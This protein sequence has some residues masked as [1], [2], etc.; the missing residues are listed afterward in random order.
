MKS[1]ALTAILGFALTA[2]GAIA[3]VI[4]DNTVGTIVSPA[5]LI[6]GGT[7]T[8]NNLF[9]SFSQF[10]IP[11]GGSATFDNP[12]NIQ[13]IFS[14]VTGTTKS[15]IDGL[16]QANGNTNL[17][18][19]NPNGIVFGPNAKLQIGGSFIGTTANSIKFADGVQ[20]SAGDTTPNPLLTVSLPIG[21][22]M[23]ANSGAIEVQGPGHTLT[24]LDS[25]G[26]APLIQLTRPGLQ[27]RPGQLLALVGSDVKLNNGV[28]GAVQGRVEI[29]SLA[30]GIVTLSI[31]TPSTPFS[32][33]NDSVFN[34]VILTGRS[35]LDVSGVNAGGIQIQGRQIS[36][37]DGSVIFSQNFGNQSGGDIKINASQSLIV[38]G[39]SS[40]RRI[41]TAIESET[42]GLGIGS[43]IVINSPTIQVK[44]G[45]RIAAI[46][47]NRSPIASN[48][49]SGDIQITTDSLLLQGV[50]IFNSSR[51]SSLG[52]ATAGTGTSGSVSVIAKD[53]Q[54]LDGATLSTATFG[55]G[56]SGS[57]DLKADTVM[58]DHISPLGSPSA[59]G[60]VSFSNG[61]S[62]TVK[63]DT[64]S[65]KI[66]NGGSLAATAYAKGNAG[67][68]IVNAS[69][70]VQLQGFED[71]VDIRNRSNIISAS[72]IPS[73]TFIRLLNLTNVPSGTAGSI[74][75]NTPNLNLTNKALISV[76]NQGTGGGGNL[77]IAAGKIQLSQD[78]KLTAE[79]YSGLGGDIILNSQF[80]S[81]R[82]ASNITA[83]AG[84]QGNGGNIKINSPIIVGLEN[85][86]IIANAFQGKGGAI[87]ITTDGLLGLKYRDRLTTENDITASS[88]FGINGTVQIDSFGLDPS[89]GLSALPGDV[90]DSSRA[91]AKGCAANQGNRFVSTG[92]GGIPQNPIKTVKHDRPWNDLRAMTTST[93]VSQIQNPK[94]KI[95]EATH[96]QTNSDG[97]IA[98]ADGE[99]MASDLPKVIGLNSGATCAVQ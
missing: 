78:S 95:V 56:M 39:E 85:S 67:N 37:Q 19:M 73:L 58:L 17:F 30:N 34:A 88:E 77:S 14:R 50:S 40:D 45:A 94:F 10:S 6:T 98:L 44:Q 7:R 15:S 75:I 65:L 21:L 33:S 8:G 12:A 26:F 5:N 13:T 81:L 55:S 99:S 57:I 76:R 4:P 96:I 16:I 91:I 70:S 24:P 66:F 48:A 23:G 69:E 2:Q 93:I 28:L 90:I 89:S 25:L 84:S 27:V 31:T 9:H 60:S 92:R 41:R 36:F 20:F 29:G 79:T 63:V 1:I 3:Q 74:E 32:Y 97:T 35:L 86:D 71:S 43:K 22:Q 53:V 83:T 42:L 82:K 51:T 68:I 54:I 47:F 61:N 18:L 11:A 64:R 62:G 80:L 49:V 87:E 46:T 38:N 72:V 52:T 59:L